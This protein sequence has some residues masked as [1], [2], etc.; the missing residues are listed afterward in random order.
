MF[1]LHGR[2][3]GI[4]GGYLDTCHALETGDRMNY[5]PG[6]RLGLSFKMGYL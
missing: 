3:L 4:G 5:A 1:F 6:G 2:K